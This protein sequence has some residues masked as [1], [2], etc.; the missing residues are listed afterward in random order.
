[1][2]TSNKIPPTDL[3]D[4]ILPKIKWWWL[5]YVILCSLIF[6]L[7]APHLTQNP[8][9]WFELLFVSSIFT[10]GALYSLNRN[11][12]RKWYWKSIF[13]LIILHFLFVTY[14]YWDSILKTS[15]STVL[16][17]GIVCIPNT[18][19]IF[20]YAYSDR[21]K[22]ENVPQTPHPNKKTPRNKWSK[23]IILVMTFIAITLSSVFIL[24]FFDHQ[25][26]LPLEE[27]YEILLETLYERGKMH[28]QGNGVP[29]NNKQAIILY[30]KAAEQ[31]YMEAQRALAS[32]YAN[33]E[34]TPKDDKQAVIWFKKAAEQGDAY[35][36]YVLGI[37]YSQGKGVSKDKQ[38]SK[39]WFRKAAE[40]GDPISQFKLGLML[41]DKK[42]SAKWF[43]KSA[44]QGK[45]ESKFFLGLLYYGTEGVPQ[46]YKQ[47]KRWFQE[48]AE[49]NYADAQY[50]LGL[51]LY[52]GKGEPKDHKKA[53]MWFKKSAEQGNAKAQ[54]ILTEIEKRTAPNRLV[55]VA[56]MFTI[57]KKW[58]TTE[59]KVKGY[60]PITGLS[61]S[62]KG[63]F[64]EV[65]SCLKNMNENSSKNMSCEELDSQISRCEPDLLKNSPKELNSK[66]SQL[67]TVKFLECI[68][69]S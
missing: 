42:E 14:A 54:K 43:R 13:W 33:G 15:L 30:R 56:D 31:G 37:S 63:S 57:T 11:F 1:M 45:V 29:Q 18:Y 28:Q 55:A 16:F 51:M 52:V 67:L 20:K 48:A 22:S 66:D 59:C 40:Q 58:L 9:G 7:I 50:M 53:I 4:E 27:K 6:L 46:D 21:L 62:C 64:P 69:Q 3:P 35:S 38:E 39:K 10:G 2:N 34:G 41:E 19:L 5:A 24:K 65:I 23:L 60:V 12:L 26:N 68:I 25:D 8:L 47:A 36:Q 32:M 17:I 49:Q 61:T 44:K